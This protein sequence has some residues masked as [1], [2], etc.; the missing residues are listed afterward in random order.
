MVGA[1]IAVVVFTTTNHFK[2]QLSAIYYS[3]GGLIG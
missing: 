3:H 1:A 2:L